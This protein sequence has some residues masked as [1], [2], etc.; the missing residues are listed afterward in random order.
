MQIKIN[1]APVRHQNAVMSVDTVLFQLLDLFEEPGNI[2]H[3]SCTNEVDASVRENARSYMTD[4]LAYDSQ[5]HLHCAYVIY[6]RQTLCRSSQDIH[7]LPL[8][9]VTPLRTENHCRHRLDSLR[10]VVLAYE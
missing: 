3:A 5:A 2:D 4:A 7:D 9:F 6:A 1:V 8:A 10:E